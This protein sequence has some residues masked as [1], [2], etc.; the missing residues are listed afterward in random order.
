MGV[1]V[2]PRAREE[3]DGPR[4]MDV[5]RDMDGI[6]RLID[7]VFA[8]DIAIEGRQLQRDLAIM[9]AASPL[10]WGLRRVS[11]EFRDAFDGFVWVERGRI[12]GNV[13]LTRDDPARHVW[14][15]TNVAVHPDYRRRG[16]ARALMQEAISAVAQRGGGPLALEVKASNEAAR[17]LYL[18]LG[19]HFV[20][21]T[22]TF[23]HA[24]S[25]TGRMPD[26]AQVRLAR[27]ADWP[28]LYHL[29]L[30]A[31]SADALL[32]SPVL[33][34]DFRPSAARHLRNS[35]HDLLLQQQRFWLVVDEGD[36]LLAAARVRL[37]AGDSSRVIITI[38]PNGRGRAEESIVQGA[39]AAR[40]RGRDLS[41]QVGSDE[42]RAHSILR[43]YE[44]T[45]VRHLHRL[46]LTVDPSA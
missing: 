9:A 25:V 12:V 1:L 39:I 4:P 24:G 29:A 45:L 15:I 31:H 6:G 11:A 46:M 19:F 42:L 44:F 18:N 26:A 35:L 3:Q 28:R 10:L 5:V 23:R 22:G 13:T 33:E 21:G 38:H 16:I 27:P 43:A 34:T 37:R 7:L 40:G 41:V 36:R 30:A 14:T 32:L 2:I 20:D 8:D 17:A